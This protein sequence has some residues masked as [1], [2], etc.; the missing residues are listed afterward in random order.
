MKISDLIKMGLRNLFRRKARTALTIIGMVIGTISIVVMFS[1]GNG[2]NNVFDEAVMK[3]GGLS[4]I[5]VY[6]MYSWDEST[7]AEIKSAELNDEIVEQIKG[8]EHVKNVSP[9]FGKQLHLKNGKYENFIQVQIIDFASASDFGYPNLKDGTSLSKENNKKIVLCENDMKN[10][11]LNT[12]RTQKN[13]EVDLT[14]D[15]VIAEFQDYQIPEGKKKTFNFPVNEN[16]GFL[17]ATPDSQYGWSSYMDIDY[18]KELYTKYANTLKAEDRKKAFKSLGVYEQ[19]Y[20]NVDDIRNVTGVV[21][22]INKLGV[23]SYSA[24]NDLGPM[25]QTAKMLQT[26]F[27]AIGGVALLV[28]AINIA[29][30]MVM[31]I[32]ERTKEIGVMKVLGCLVRDV[33]KLF[34]FEAGLI[35]LIGGIIGVGLSYIASW[36]V[37]KYGGPLLSSI[38]PGNNWYVDSTGAQFSQIPVELPFLAAAVSIGVGVLAGYFP[39][40]RATKISA[41]EAMKTEG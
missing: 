8:I 28:S 17:D 14:K 18:F 29:N 24:M 30:T 16:Y 40:R 25:K 3:D 19:I 23:T 41:I 15:K 38:V 7:G 34:L 1:I 4:L 6:Q 12:G 20:V 37:N 27:L 36:A 31:S 13:K 2:I 10:F 33:K 9:I 11:F 21:E 5:Y 35:G 22:E 32:Y 26:V 39:A